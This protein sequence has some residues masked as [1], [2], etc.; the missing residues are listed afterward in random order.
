[1]LNSI[2]Q[3]PVQNSYKKKHKLLS[4]NGKVTIYLDC[5]LN[6]FNNK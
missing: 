1:M 3:I 5:E 2:L 4:D 6:I